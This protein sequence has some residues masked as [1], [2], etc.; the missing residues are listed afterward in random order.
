MVGSR[1]AGAVAH[2]GRVTTEP[3]HR[4]SHTHTCPSWKEG[5][6]EITGAK[7]GWWGEEIGCGPEVTNVV[8]SFVWFC[9]RIPPFS[10]LF[11]LNRPLL[12]SNDLCIFPQ[13]NQC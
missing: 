6:S 7:L 13:K 12:L 8:T 1:E 10:R 3:S 2:T 11:L 9:L 4:H 5:L